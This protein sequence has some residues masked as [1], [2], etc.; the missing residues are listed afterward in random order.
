MNI[1]LKKSKQAISSSE[2]D[3]FEAA[4]NATL[5]GDYRQFLSQ[6][7]GSKPET[8]IFKVNERTDSGVNAFIPL[9]ELL[10]ERSLIGDEIPT[11]A[12]P[13]AWAEGGN[14]VCLDLGNAGAVFFWDHEEPER[15]TQLARSFTAFLDILRPFDV[16][17]I[18][19]KPGQVKSAW[20]D[21]SLLQ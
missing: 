4:F 8:N 13:I 21:P 11:K 18:K 1:K 16:S 14:F 5:P 17:S 10:K 2:I 20:I 7:N 12:I 19:L 9:T 15:P 3:G 6:Y